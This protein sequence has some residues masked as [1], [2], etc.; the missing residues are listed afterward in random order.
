LDVIAAPGQLNR[1]ALT[2]MKYRNQL[3]QAK[4]LS[5]TTIIFLVLVSATTCGFA[6]GLSVRTIFVQWKPASGK[7]IT[8]GL[9]NIELTQREIAI[10]TSQQVGGTFTVVGTQVHGQHNDSNN[11]TRVVIV[12]Q[13]QIDRPVELRQPISDA[14]YLQLNNEWKLLPAGTKTNDRLIRLEPSPQGADQT[15]YWFQ[16]PDGARQG[17]NAFIW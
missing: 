17:G 9:K 15:M 3:L 13:R 2:L 12:M 16:L 7:P 1:S 10:L 4:F 6:D 14:V 8:R 5:L 11:Q